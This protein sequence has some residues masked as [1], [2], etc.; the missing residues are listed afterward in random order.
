[1]P[2]M[3]IFE[4]NHFI[5]MEVIEGVVPRAIRMHQNAFIFKMLRQYGMDQCN[6]VRTPMVPSSTISDR[7]CWKMCVFLLYK[8]AH[9]SVD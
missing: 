1:M 5:G 7:G 9:A 8:L 2:Q 3:H 4:Q 6:S